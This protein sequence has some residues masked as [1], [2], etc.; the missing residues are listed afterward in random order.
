MTVF[1]NVGVFKRENVWLD[2]SLSYDDGWWYHAKHVEQFPHKIDCVSLHLD[3]YILEYHY[4]AG[5]HKR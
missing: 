4:D 2:N 1:E 3:G 5:T